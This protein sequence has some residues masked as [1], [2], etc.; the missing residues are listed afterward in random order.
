MRQEVRHMPSDHQNSDIHWVNHNIVENRVSGN[1]LADARPLMVVAN[2]QN[3]D[4]IPSMADDKAL[5]DIYLV[6][7][8]HILVKRIPAL[9]CLRNHIPKHIRHRHSE[10]M[11]KQ[12]KK[13]LNMPYFIPNTPKKPCYFLFILQGKEILHLVTLSSHTEVIGFTTTCDQTCDVISFSSYS[14]FPQNFENLS[15][16][17]FDHLGFHG[18]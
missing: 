5:Y 11:R 13:V 18:N 7:I 3:K 8:Q 12:S 4:L 16:Y 14:F 6:H 2:V 9:Q 15:P 1:H 17:C 10:E